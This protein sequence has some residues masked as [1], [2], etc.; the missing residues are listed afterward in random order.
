[1]SNQSEEKADFDLIYAE[2]TSF[3]GFSEDQ[4]PSLDDLS[5]INLVK[6]LESLLPGTF[7]DSVIHHPYEDAW[8]ESD[9]KE[10]QRIRNLGRFLIEDTKR[11]FVAQKIHE[12]KV[13]INYIFD[14]YHSID[15]YTE[16]PEISHD[17]EHGRSPDSVLPENIAAFPLGG[18]VGCLG[19][20]IG[21]V[22]L[23][24]LQGFDFLYAS[25]L[26]DGTTDF[27]QNFQGINNKISRH[28]PGSYDFNG[29]PNLSIQVFDLFDGKNREAYAG[30]PVL[31][32]LYFDEPT[33]KELREY[34]HFLLVNK[35]ESDK[36]RPLVTQLD[37]YSLIFKQ[38]DMHAD[39]L[40]LIQ[41]TLAPG[42][43]YIARDSMVEDTY[44]LLN[45]HLDKMLALTK[46]YRGTLE[47]MPDQEGEI[48]ESTKKIVA[49]LFSTVNSDDPEQFA[50][51][52]TANILERLIVAQH[53]ALAEKMGLD[54]ERS[55]LLDSVRKDHPGAMYD[56]LDLIRNTFMER[57]RKN[58]ELRRFNASLRE[59]FPITAFTLLHRYV[60]EYWFSI[61]HSGPPNKSAEIGETDFSV[62]TMF[63]NHYANTRKDG[64][65][66]VARYLA[67]YSSSQ[68]IWLAAMCDGES[69][70][71]PSMMAVGEQVK[72]LKPSQLHP[73]VHLVVKN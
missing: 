38:H 60:L 65:V 53:V 48:T 20:S 54:T 22:A 61:R 42:S 23:A 9:H 19:V 56:M 64:R 35:P 59:Q 72:L 50:S 32:P 15:W 8:T 26:R 45:S 1:M 40:K 52:L 51:D 33:A 68:L 28:F 37:P 16:H 30:M 36:K 7:L 21:M 29:F 27:I 10:I 46:S 25:E 43:T 24:E 55:K 73:R 6:E 11:R 49:E 18:Y 2:A 12:E 70:E 67:R 71:D 47:A 41:H 14:T 57:G 5:P 39:E 13:D 62:G 66:N 63:L 44:K 58:S 31:N 17:P 69:E 34:H 3:V 4:H